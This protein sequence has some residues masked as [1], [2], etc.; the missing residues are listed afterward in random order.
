M[1][2]DLG[3][4]VGTIACDAFEVSSKS[5]VQVSA[6]LLGERA[7]GHV[8]NQQVFEPKAAAVGRRGILEYKAGP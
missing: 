2:D 1:G 6:I 3:V 4:F 8:P 5:L 7:V